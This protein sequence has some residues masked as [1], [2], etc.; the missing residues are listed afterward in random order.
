M[1]QREPT[2]QEIAKFARRQDAGY[3]F[4]TLLKCKK[5]KNALEGEIGQILFEDLLSIMEE[6]I[7]AIYTNPLDA[8]EEDKIMLKLC[9]DLGSRWNKKIKNYQAMCRKVITEQ[10]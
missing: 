8:K 5:F 7:V 3:V 6:K 10:S 9:Q 1:K 2:E 4:Q